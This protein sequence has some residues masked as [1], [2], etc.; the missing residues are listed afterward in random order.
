MQ[1]RDDVAVHV[2]V[3]ARLLSGSPVS[4]ALDG[5]T[6]AAEPQTTEPAPSSPVAQQAQRTSSLPEYRC[7]VQ[8]VQNLQL[9]L[10][11]K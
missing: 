3:S 4:S 2:A 7:V 6:P 5:A 10:I 11:V 8:A 9:T 1:L